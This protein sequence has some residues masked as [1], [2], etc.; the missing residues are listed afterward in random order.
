MYI[1]IGEEPITEPLRGGEI[2]TTNQDTVAPS[3]P[4]MWLVVSYAFVALAV[5]SFAGI[6]ILAIERGFDFSTDTKAWIVGGLGMTVIASVVL[7]L[8]SA[9]RYDAG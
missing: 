1:V 3:R 8:A 9:R 4:A 7:A 6:V 2:M 5:F